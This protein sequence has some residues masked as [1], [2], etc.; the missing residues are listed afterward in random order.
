AAG[1]PFQ[2]LSNDRLG[3]GRVPG[4]G[5]QVALD[6]DGGRFFVHGQGPKDPRRLRSFYAFPVHPVGPRQSVGRDA[7]AGPTGSR[8]G[9]PLEP[10]RLI[11][12]KHSRKTG[13]CSRKRRLLVLARTTH[14]SR[15][16]IA[17]GTSRRPP[18]AAAAWSPPPVRTSAC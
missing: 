9:S 10:G 8:G 12:R 7:G 2:Q 16:I 5:V 13:D 3:G 17:G 1:R 4:Q 15:S 6:D 14:I 18:L 11:M